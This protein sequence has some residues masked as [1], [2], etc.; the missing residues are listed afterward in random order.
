[1]AEPSK[2]YD[3]ASIRARVESEDLSHV[4]E[5]LDRVQTSLPGE[6]Q[7]LLRELRLAIDATVALSVQTGRPVYMADARIPQA[8][9]ET[10]NGAVIELV[11]R[12]AFPKCGVAIYEPNVR[13]MWSK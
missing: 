12:D 5:I 9:L 2:A 6:V 1:M 11:V 8:L 13:V 10:F 3:A 7:E 4:K